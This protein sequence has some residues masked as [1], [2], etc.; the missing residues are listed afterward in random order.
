MKD[1]IVFDA[2]LAIKECILQ[3]AFTYIE[4]RILIQFG[5]L[6]SGREQDIQFKPVIT[7][8]PASVF[9]VIALFIFTYAYILFPVYS[10]SAIDAFLSAGNGNGLNKWV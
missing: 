3:L 5:R 9:P 7:K 8:S 4:R 1:D 10:Q 2:I 6:Q